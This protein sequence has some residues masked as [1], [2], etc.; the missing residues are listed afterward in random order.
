MAGIHLSHLLPNAVPSTV[1]AGVASGVSTITWLVFLPVALTFGLLAEH[2]GVHSGGW[3]ITGFTATP[4]CAR[5][6]PWTGATS[7]SSGRQACPWAGG[8]ITSQAP[9]NVSLRV[10]YPSDNLDY[11]SA[12]AIENTPTNQNR[13][14]IL[15]QAI[16]AY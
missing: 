11:V 9:P 5:S 2:H 15:A 16:C 13:D 3:V 6:P 8:A 1:R 12:V 14:F 4:T 10:V 7:P